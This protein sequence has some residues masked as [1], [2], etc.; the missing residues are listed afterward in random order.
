MEMIPTEA[1]LKS[2][3]RYLRIDEE[4]T[5]QDEELQEYVMIAEDY[6]LAAGIEKSYFDGRYRLAISKFVMHEYDNRGENIG[7]KL[8]DLVISMKIRPPKKENVED[9][10]QTD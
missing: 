4:D 1:D 3:K 5:D 7:D 10:S 9:G 6:L 8:N 2:I